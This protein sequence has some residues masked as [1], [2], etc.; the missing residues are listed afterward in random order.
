MWQSL[1][2]CIAQESKLL[3]WLTTL[4]PAWAHLTGHDVY[5]ACK[6]AMAELILSGCTTTSDH[7]YLYP[8]DVTLDDS[9]RAAREIGIRF[10]PTRGV[11]S[12]GLSKGGVAPDSCTEDEA[13]CL[14]DMHRCIGEFHDNSRYSMLRMAL[15]PSTCFNVTDELMV[16]TA[17]LA[18][19]HP[20]VRLHTHLAETEEETALAQR[21]CGCGLGEHLRDVEWE[22]EDVWFAHCCF[23][24]KAEVQ[25]LAE[26][27]MG[28]A[29]C[30]SSNL[31]LASGIAP[32]KA[33]LRA[34]VN[35]GLGV[36]GT[37]S[38]G[39]GHLLQEAR[40][41][42]LLQ[43]A[44]G[45]AQAMGAHDS[46]T[47][48]TEGGARNLGRNDIGKIAPGFAAD[49]VAWRM[50]ALGFSGSGRDPVAALLFCTPSVGLVDLSVIN[51]H[52]VVQDGQL[53]TLNLQ[54]LIKEHRACSERLCQHLPS[55]WRAG[56]N[57]SASPL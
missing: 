40:M 16:S 43:R 55:S 30:P 1:T 10:H 50:D 25:Q 33:L 2:R 39:S 47:M 11:T 4:Y 45:S 38:S 26:K 17:R 32:L 22:G 3:E 49:I 41:S 21:I 44:S 37:A 35:V 15:A 9:I 31:R 51:G 24:D 12:L 36:D 6:L 56:G 8:N 28:V 27:G 48:A 29:H 14:S 57:C 46:L 20:G 52:T 42:M 53:L 13:A 7:L 34:G 23:L 18:R 54:S 5:T 19:R